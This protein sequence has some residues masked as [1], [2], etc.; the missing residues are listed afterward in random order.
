MISVWNAGSTTYGT[1]LYRRPLTGTL[2]RSGLVICPADAKIPERR[3]RPATKAADAP[4]AVAPFDRDIP[5]AAKHCLDRDTGKPNLAKLLK[6]YDQ[7]LLRYHLHPEAKFQGGEYI[8]SALPNT[9]TFRRTA[10]I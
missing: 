6:T 7:A 8:H 4:R 10:S 3:S 5:K 1:G 2:I 9:A